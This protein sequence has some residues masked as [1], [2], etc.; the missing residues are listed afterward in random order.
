V[1]LGSI[2][3]PHH[4]GQ[5]T[6]IAPKILQDEPLEARSLYHRDV[7][8][9]GAANLDA[10]EAV[11][12]EAKVQPLVASMDVEGLRDGALGD[13]QVDVPV[14]H[15]DAADAKLLEMGEGG[16]AQQP[17]HVRELP[18]ADVEAGEGGDGEERHW[19]GH[20]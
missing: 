15:D 2:T 9:D 10:P 13:D 5:A 16:V 7:L 6:G 1:Q 17:G 14:F 4:G 18:E 8:Q 20:V 11:A 12:D 3:N 19:E